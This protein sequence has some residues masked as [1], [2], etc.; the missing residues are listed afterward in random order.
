M[1]GLEPIQPD[2]HFSHPHNHGMRPVEVEAIPMPHDKQ[3]LPVLPFVG[4]PVRPA[5][6]ADGDRPM[7][8]GPPGRRPMWHHG[9]GPHRHASF[10]R[11]VHRALMMLGPWEG[12]AVAFVLGEYLY[13]LY[14]SP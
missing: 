12:R 5:F 3:P 8:D 10:L 6:V 7:M 1:L 11:R 9:P 13:S 2:P 4:T 14:P